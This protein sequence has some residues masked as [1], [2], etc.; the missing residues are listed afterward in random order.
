MD[1]VQQQA[2]FWEDR[3]PRRFG[4]SGGPFRNGWVCSQIRSKIQTKYPGSSCSFVS[5]F[6]IHF[7]AARLWEAYVTS[8]DVVALGACLPAP[9]GTLSSFLGI[10]FWSDLD[11][12][13]NPLP[14]D[15]VEEG[16]AWIH[17][18]VSADR[19]VYTAMLANFSPDRE[20]LFRRRR[21]SSSP[22]RSMPIPVARRALVC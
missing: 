12:I 22:R 20:I 1:L 2:V 15:R 3:P 14:S 17:Q 16:V 10:Q 11:R 6:V 9:T 19:C 4:F 8:R 21:S 5:R 18:P 13:G 7:L